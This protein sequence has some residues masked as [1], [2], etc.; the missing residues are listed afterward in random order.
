M[1]AV[2]RSTAGLRLLQR[3]VSQPRAHERRRPTSR[4]HSRA[5]PSDVVTRRCSQMDCPD[6]CL[7]QSSGRDQQRR[8]GLK[9][10]C[11]WN[12]HL[13]ERRQAARCLRRVSSTE[14]VVLRLSARGV[15]AW[16]VR[17]RVPLLPHHR[18]NPSHLNRAKH[19][20]AKVLGADLRAYGLSHHYGWPRKGDRRGKR[21]RSIEDEWS[22]LR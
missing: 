3:P 15:F 10:R 1:V 14:K 9:A 20:S 16:I 4:L 12:M 18:Y 6:R 17:A 11:F 5:T 19:I 2:E 13:V 21:A 8:L 22:R 7:R